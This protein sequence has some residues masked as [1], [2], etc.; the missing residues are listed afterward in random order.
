VGKLA[1]EIEAKKTQPEGT[2]ECSRLEV[3]E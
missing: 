1:L 2:R 3:W